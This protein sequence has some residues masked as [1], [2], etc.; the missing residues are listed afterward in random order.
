[1]N[2]YVDFN[3]FFGFTDVDRLPKYEGSRI[4]TQLT[5]KEQILGT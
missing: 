3:D 2:N 4:S 5:K 1:M